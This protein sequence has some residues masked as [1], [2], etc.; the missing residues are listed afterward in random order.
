MGF[1][2][3]VQY[4]PFYLAD[5]R[6]Y[7]TQA[8]IA[9]EF[10]YSLETS[11]VQQ[12]AAGEV[13]FALVSGEQVLLARAQG[14]PVVM[15]MAWWQDYPV[16]VAAPMDGDIENVQDLAGKRIGIPVLEGASYIGYRA[17]VR[18]AGLPEESTELEVIGFNQ[19]EAMLTEQVD[20]IVVYANNEPIQLAAQGMPMNVILVA[21][22]V[23][24]ASNGLITSEQVL[25]ENPQLVRA[26]VEASLRGIEDAIA[27][28]AEA[29]ETSKAYVEGLAEADLDVQ[30][31]VLEASIGFW[32]ADRPG[33]SEPQAWE[34][35]QEV[36]LAM[37]LL[38]TALDLEAA[39]SN[40]FIP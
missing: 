15:V 33:Y 1:I 21:D 31:Q 20:A 25:Q 27:D 18:A 40:E 19:V 37:G 10:D 24:L 23:H 4:S 12:V 36:L 26:M 7:F 17:L 2:P 35:M 11:G 28:P 38:E 14:L 32:E 9:M 5:A 3:N 30:R 39:Y 22:Y 16:A 6:E 29:L 34:N 8:G 13:P